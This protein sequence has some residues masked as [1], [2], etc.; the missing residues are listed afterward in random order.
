VSVGK[1][2]QRVLL[3]AFSTFKLGGPQARFVQLAN[4]LGADYRHIVAAM[5]NCFE[6]GDRLEPGVVW[7]PLPL[8]IVKGGA[9]ANRGALRS[10][11]QRLQPDLMLSYNWGAIE[12]AAAN[13]PRVVPHVHVE[14]GFGPE[15][16]SR[17]LPRRVWARRALLGWNRVSLAVASRNLER[18]A[19]DVWK[20]PADRVRF[21]PN[22]VHIPT[23]ERLAS[24]LPSAADGVLRIGTVAGLRPEKNIGRLI[25]A[26]GEVRARHRARLV[27]VG[28]G[29]QRE[30]LEGLA[31]QLGV[32][33][34][35]EFTGYLKDPQSRLREFDL[36]ALSSDTE[37]LP[38]ALLE[39]MAIGMPAV[40]T[41]V[42]DVG[43]LLSD[44]SPQTLCA[45][46]DVSFAQAL[47]R[48]LECQDQWSAWAQ[49]GRRKVAAA[50]SLSQMVEDWRRMFDNADIGCSRVARS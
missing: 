3:H 5:D 29:P 20:L 50:Y 12:W 45:P 4:A 40:A 31:R 13:L 43:E 44:V 48:A 1:R 32:G 2:P 34:E 11:I 25:R 23:H 46:D 24:Q 21:L 7:E 22:G 37:Q 10:V 49:A 30:E 38:L 26:F 36:F 47:S 27:V 35:V 41:H 8:E 16:A 15:E 42:G 6:A 33:D 17:Q 28:T 14:D 18:M 19:T 39:A 9:L